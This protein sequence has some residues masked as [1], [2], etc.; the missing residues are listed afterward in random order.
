MA[1]K[2]LNVLQDSYVTDIG[3]S[4]YSLCQKEDFINLYPYTGQP[5]TGIAGTKIMPD[6]IGIVKLDYN[7]NGKR[8]PL[9]LSNTLYCSSIEA[10]LVSISQLLKKGV[11]VS[12]SIDRV[13]FKYGPKLFT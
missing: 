1:A 9:L 8:V 6:S 3:C 7:L 12:F 11:Q 5:M 10:N 13:T 2:D 4:Q